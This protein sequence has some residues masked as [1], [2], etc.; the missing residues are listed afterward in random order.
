[1]ARRALRSFLFAPADNQRILDKV[2]TAGADAVVID[3]VDRAEAP[4]LKSA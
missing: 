2:F 3:L 1:M 4:D